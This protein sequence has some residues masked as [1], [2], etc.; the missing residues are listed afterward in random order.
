MKAF[1]LLGLAAV[2]LG[3]ACIYLASPHQRWRAAPWPARTARGAGA[4]LLV[5]GWLGLAQ[6][7]DRS[8]ATFTHLTL[9]ML[10]FTVLPYL[11]AL[12][13]ARPGAT[14]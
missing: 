2:L 10:A 4:V 1:T 6:H 9:L 7:M 13:A 5:L 12:R 3:C 11:G 14:P 8:T